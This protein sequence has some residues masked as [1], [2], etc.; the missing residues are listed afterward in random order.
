M[1]IS[2]C[3]KNENKIIGIGNFL[4]FRPQ[5]GGGEIYWRFHY[6]VTYFVAEN[7]YFELDKSC[8]EWE[9]LVKNYRSG[10]FP[11][12]LA[13]GGGGGE[14]DWIFLYILT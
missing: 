7:L 12:F 10:K 4:V 14:I 1:C 13:P 9:K 2:S 8:F 11:H 6:I 3:E 5:G